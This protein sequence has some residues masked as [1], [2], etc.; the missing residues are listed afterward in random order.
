VISIYSL[1]CYES[2][3]IVFHKLCKAAWSSRVNNTE[4]VSAM[5]HERSAEVSSTGWTRNSETSSSITI[6]VSK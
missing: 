4:S 3:M 6:L 1:N 2:A 5:G